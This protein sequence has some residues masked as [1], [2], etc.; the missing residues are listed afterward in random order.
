MTFSS[1]ATSSA[2][3]TASAEYPV[4]LEATPLDQDLWAVILAGGIGSR[5]W[6]LSSSQRPKQVLALVSE[7]PLIAETVARLETLVPPER[8]LV[9]TSRDIAAQ[10]HAAIPMIP[11]KNLLLEPKPLGTA[12][13]LA[14]AA[15]E[16]RHRAGPESVFACL[17]ADLAVA[18]VDAFRHVLRQATR[19]AASEDALVAIGVH[20]TRPETG[21]GYLVPGLPLREDIPLTDGGA[22]HVVAFEEK[23]ARPRAEALVREGALWNSGIFVW[24]T[25]VILDAL[26]QH[27]VEIVNSLPAVQTREYDTFVGEVR[28]ISIERGLLERCSG[29]LV[30][31]PGDFGWDDVGTWAA[32][33]RARELD[34]TGNGASGRSH[35]FDASGNVVHAEGSAV[36]LYGVDG[37]LVVTLAGLTFVTT[38]ERA[39][40]LKPLLDSLPPDLRRP[41]RPPE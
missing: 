27:C 35:F 16:V 26:A 15:G 11:E 1:S 24:R 18:F 4:P 31:L 7:R 12:A 23:P 9:V 5:F 41:G 38:V 32:L 39:A 14:W 17:H 6:P 33:R 25:R 34:D 20:S 19:V 13:S 2:L 28:S 40:D 37:L 8:I 3:A 22:C 29:N 21:F 10:I 36:V 30:V